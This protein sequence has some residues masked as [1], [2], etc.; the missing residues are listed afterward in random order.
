MSSLWKNLLFMHGYLVRKEDLLWREQTLPEPS[1]ET[2]NESS[3]DQAGGVA[4]GESRTPR[5]R[6]Q[7]R[8]SHWPRLAA[9]R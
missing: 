2:P 1:G 8:V 3:A 6:P 4:K 5:S 9:P 7:N